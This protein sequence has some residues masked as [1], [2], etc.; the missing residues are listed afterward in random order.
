MAFKDVVNHTAY[1]IAVLVTVVLC[2]WS[3]VHIWTKHKD[4]PHLTDMH[5]TL[6]ALSATCVGLLLLTLMHKFS[7]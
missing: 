4:D 2:A 6:S 7:K 1:V 3:I 5:M